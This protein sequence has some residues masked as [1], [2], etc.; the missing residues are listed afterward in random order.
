[1]DGSKADTRKPSSDPRETDLLSAVQ[2]MVAVGE[3]LLAAYQRADER[4]RELMAALLA[5]KEITISQDEGGRVE[6][7]SVRPVVLQ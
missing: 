6:G 7:G 2:A 1:M 3:A 5:P 4:H